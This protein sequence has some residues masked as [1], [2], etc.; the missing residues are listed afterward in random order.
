MPGWQGSTRRER[1]PANWATEI[2][3]RILNRDGHQCTWLTNGVRCTQRATDVD[4]IQR[5]DNHEDW[6]LRSL[7]SPHHRAKSS[8]EGGTAP[9]RRSRYYV[10][11]PE[12]PHPGMKRP[13]P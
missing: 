7:C 13:K 2:R 9:R 4:H 3:P 1:L 5:G 8:R 12:E 6:N 11:R 10:K